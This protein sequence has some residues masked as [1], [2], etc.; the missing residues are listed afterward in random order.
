MYN[1]SMTTVDQILIQIVNYSS[2]AIEELVSKRD[3][4]ILRS[5]ASA[6]LS[7]NFLTENQSKLLLRILCENQEKLK[8]DFFLVSD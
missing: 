2:T 4:R 5:M 6:V 7:S 8:S 1:K 3:A